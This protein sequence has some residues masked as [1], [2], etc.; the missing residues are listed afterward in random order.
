VVIPLGITMPPKEPS[1]VSMPD[2]PDTERVVLFA[3]RLA[4]YKGIHHLVRAMRGVDARLVIVGSG[5]R[6][7]ALKQLAREEGLA[8]QVIFKG[9]VPDEELDRWYRRCDVFV[10]PSTSPAETTGI[11][12][13]EAMARRKPVVN[14][15]LPTDVP[16]VSQHGVTGLTVEPGSPL[17]LTRA[18]NTLLADDG[19]RS[20]LGENGRLRVQERYTLDAMNRSVAEIYDELLGT[21][22]VEQAKP[23]IERLAA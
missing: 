12:Q 14:T 16:E 18:I 8:E 11:V 9:R 22:A 6:E 13:L 7:R 4:Y 20:W 5:E 23:L 15:S 10:L 1:F 17:A 2:V 21:A 3:G 19:L